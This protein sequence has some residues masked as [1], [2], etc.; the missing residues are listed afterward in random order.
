MTSLRRAFYLLIGLTFPGFWILH[1][2]GFAAF[3][4]QPLQRFLHTASSGWP[5]LVTAL[6]LYGCMIAC[7]EVLM[8]ARKQIQP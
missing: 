7:F 2:S 4:Y 1:A 6:L 3:L 8:R 5:S